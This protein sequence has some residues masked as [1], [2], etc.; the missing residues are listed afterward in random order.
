MNIDG[1]IGVGELA[2]A[3]TVSDAFYR[4]V[5]YLGRPAFS[6]SSR[7]VLL[8]ADRVPATGP[9]IVATN[10]LSP[11]D[12]PCLMGAIARPLDFV[13]VVEMFRNPLV[14][15]FFR[16]MNAFPLD[17][18][19]VDAGT[20]RIILD[21]LRRGRVVAMF[22]EGRIREPHESMLV[23]GPVRLSVVRLARLAGSPIV[24]GVILGTGMFSRRSAWKPVGKTKY[25]VAF[26]Y[27][28]LVDSEHD[29]AAACAAGET[30]LMTAYRE[31]YA[32]LSA[33]CGLTVADQPWRSST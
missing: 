30:Q 26:G 21:R 8:H 14:A 20:T 3:G 19:R 7:P 5:R 1:R 29:E 13:S 2:K 15:W 9:A 27:P 4:L 32:E 12:I 16:N 11:Y 23:G 31:L 17:R 22:P 25:G 33:A 10:H 24:P 28:I 6:R 18:G